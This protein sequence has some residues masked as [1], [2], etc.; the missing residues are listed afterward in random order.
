[1]NA[2][3]RWMRGTIPDRTLRKRKKNRKDRIFPYSSIPLLTTRFYSSPTDQTTVH[4][5][6]KVRQRFI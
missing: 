1:M 5:K 4:V 2:D 3:C 6:N